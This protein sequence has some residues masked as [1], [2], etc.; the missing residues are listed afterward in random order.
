MLLTE[1]GWKT[2]EMAAPCKKYGRVQGSWP[3]VADSGSADSSSRN[4]YVHMWVPGKQRRGR[5]ALNYEARSRWNCENQGNYSRTFGFRSKHRS[6]HVLWGK[7]D[8]RVERPWRHLKSMKSETGKNL[9]LIFDPFPWSQQAPG[10]S[11]YWLARA[12]AFP[13]PQGGLRH[14]FR[15]SRNLQAFWFT[16]HRNPNRAPTAV[17]ELPFPKLSGH[18]LLAIATLIKVSKGDYLHILHTAGCKQSCLDPAAMEAGSH[19]DAE[20]NTVALASPAG[21]IP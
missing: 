14:H 4:H 13:A 8:G 18:R 15:S 17:S 5:A 12:G 16:V 3:N 6:A 1:S 11:R 20:D 2:I 10:Q 9:P 7:G 19:F 21:M